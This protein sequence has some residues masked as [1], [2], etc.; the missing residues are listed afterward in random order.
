MRESGVRKEHKC[1]IVLFASAQAGHRVAWAGRRDGHTED[2][3]EGNTPHSEQQRL[4]LDLCSCPPGRSSPAL[5]PSGPQPPPNTH[6]GGPPSEPPRTPAAE[7]SP[8]S[9]NSLFCL[10]ES[11]LYPGCWGSVGPRSPSPLVSLP[12]ALICQVPPGLAR[13]GLLC[14]STTPDPPAGAGTVW[15]LKSDPELHGGEDPC[16]H[17]YV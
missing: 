3:L 4:R 17:F 12:A 7:P 8:P 16:P 5:P 15:P 9:L 14:G 1:V 6:T 11:Q 13:P 2:R 10:L